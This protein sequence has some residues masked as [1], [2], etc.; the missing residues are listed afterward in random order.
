MKER[1]DWSQMDTLLDKEVSDQ[2]IRIPHPLQLFLLRMDLGTF[3]RDLDASTKT[4]FRMHLELSLHAL[5]VSTELL[6]YGRLLS[7]I[8]VHQSGKKA[9][10]MSS[11]KHMLG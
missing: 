8:A 4:L 6:Q 1:A 2:L 3:L 9:M 10:R 5:D 11:Q 7:S